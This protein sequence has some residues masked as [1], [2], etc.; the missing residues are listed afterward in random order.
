MVILNR[1]SRGVYAM[2]LIGL[3]R[4]MYELSVC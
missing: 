2:I 4:G 3:D 1:A